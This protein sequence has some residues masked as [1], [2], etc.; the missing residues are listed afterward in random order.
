VGEVD[1]QFVATL[2][3]SVINRRVGLVDLDFDAVADRSRA[4]RR[5]DF[6]LM[7]SRYPSAVVDIAL[8]TPMTL[9][10]QDLAYALRGASELVEEVLLFDVYNGASLTPGTRSLAYSVRLSSPDRTLSDGEVSG[11]RDALIACAGQLGASLR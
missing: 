8:V 10:A 11:A 1:P 9:N 3:P 6:V 7:P 5:S 2:V 4:T